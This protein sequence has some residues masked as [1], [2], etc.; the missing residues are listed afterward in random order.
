L[1]PDLN[2]TDPQ[3]VPEPSTALVFGVIA[4]SALAWKRRIGQNAA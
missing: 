4:V 3:P 1:T 2:P